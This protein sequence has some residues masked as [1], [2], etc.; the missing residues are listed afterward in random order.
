MTPTWVAI[1]EQFLE[2]YKTYQYDPEFLSDVAGNEI[3]RMVT[4]YETVSWIT[5][6]PST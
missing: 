3:G 2:E 1:E 6:M 4:S 5:R